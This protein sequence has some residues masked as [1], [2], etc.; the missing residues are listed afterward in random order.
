MIYMLSNY[1]V[2]QN[3]HYIH[4]VHA[5]VLMN[6]DE[7]ENHYTTNRNRSL[8]F[9]T[10]TESYRSKFQFHSIQLARGNY[11]W[12]EKSSGAAVQDRIVRS[13]QSLSGAEHS[14]PS[15]MEIR[16]SRGTTGTEL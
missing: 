8:P 14:F 11:F 15:L 7:R 13:L 16:V 4:A 6:R 12:N 9:T 3:S 1:N 2:S 5:C 10:E